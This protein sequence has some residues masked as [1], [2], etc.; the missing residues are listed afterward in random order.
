MKPLPS[1][2]SYFCCFFSLFGAVVCAAAHDFW[3]MVINFFFAVLNW[4][5]AEH[6]KA[7]EEQNENTGE[8][9]TDDTEDKE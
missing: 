4:Y 8:R 2:L 1:K 7:R 3:F 6:N 5:V 9:D